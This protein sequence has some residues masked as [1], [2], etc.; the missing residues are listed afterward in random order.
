M[1]VSVE[2]EAFQVGGELRHPSAPQID[3]RLNL[4]GR[5]GFDELIVHR[6]TLGVEPQ[7][8]DGEGRLDRIYDA[9]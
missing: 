3:P 8:N 2:P 5:I 7:P 1:P 6:T 4:E 9:L